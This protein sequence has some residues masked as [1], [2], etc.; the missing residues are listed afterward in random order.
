MNIA[1]IADDD[2]K[3]LMANLCVAYRHILIKHTLYATGTTGKAI[4][5]AANLSVNKFLAGKLGGV[6]QVGALFSDGTI[7]LLI[8]LRQSVKEQGACDHEIMLKLCDV[9]NILFATN[10]MT[11]EALLQF[12]D[13]G[14]T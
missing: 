2:K 9:H 8:Y 7:D 14:E 5:R 13:R 1:F 6:H 3:I 12:I 4:E 10:L 11:A